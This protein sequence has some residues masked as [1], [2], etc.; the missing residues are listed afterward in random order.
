MPPADGMGM[1]LTIAS[2]PTSVVK[3]P[4]LP[5]TMGA[6]PGS[7]GPG[8][9]TTSSEL[10]TTVP[11]MFSSPVTTLASDDELTAISTAVNAAQRNVAYMT[12]AP[13]GGF[14]ILGAMHA[15]VKGHRH[16]RLLRCLV[17]TCRCACD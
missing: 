7:L 10:K 3:V 2:E 11:V 5:A 17:A 16:R 4:P 1:S 13:A 14:C 6:V 15:S 12:E 9:K 8:V